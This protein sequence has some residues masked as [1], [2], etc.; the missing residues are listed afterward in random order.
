[1][2][3]TNNEHLATL[4]ASLSLFSGVEIVL[5]KG[6]NVEFELPITSEDTLSKDVHGSNRKVSAKVVSGKEK[7]RR[8]SEGEVI[9]NPI[10]SGNLAQ[11]PGD[12]PLTV[13]IPSSGYEV[14]TITGTTRDLSKPDYFIESDLTKINSVAITFHNIPEGIITYIG[15]VDNPVIGLTLAL[16]IA[17]HNIPEV[18]GLAEPLGAFLCMLFL[19]KWV[20]NY[21]FGFLFGL[22]GGIMTH[23]SI[24]ELI[25]TG[26]S[27]DCEKNYTITAMLCG[28]AF[29][30]I[31][32]ILICR[33]CSNHI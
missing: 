10:I 19:Q 25:P 5:H 29:I 24:Y 26:I 15:Y 23:I 18:S 14:K 13:T 7:N 28:I 2:E 21:I 20:N 16:G 6:S 8:L 4:Y 17:A 32:L 9:P 31:S 22:T 27:F 12:E 30:L 33:V 3:G 1:M 11:S